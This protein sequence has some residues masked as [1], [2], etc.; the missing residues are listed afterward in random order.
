[1]C[2]IAGILSKN[3]QNIVPLVETMLSCMTTRGPDGAG[4][5]CD[6]KILQ[7]K[8]LSDLEFHKLSGSTALGHLRLAIVGGTC[9]Q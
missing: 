7:S 1:M 8:S 5:A 6:N 4:I 9:G 3:N 2:G